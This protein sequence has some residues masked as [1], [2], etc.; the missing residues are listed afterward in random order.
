M[1]HYDAGRKEKNQ[2]VLEEYRPVSVIHRAPLPPMPGQQQVACH[3][4]NA[5][6]R[7]AMR[8]VEQQRASEHDTAVRCR[9]WLAPASTVLPVV[10]A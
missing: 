2:R 8:E 10:S 9:T 3:I 7:A 5:P 1:R 6:N 4:R